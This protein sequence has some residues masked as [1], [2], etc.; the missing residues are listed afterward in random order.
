MSNNRLV[1]GNINA[2]LGY[3][4]TDY[5]VGPAVNMKLQTRS[6][7]LVEYLT[8]QNRSATERKSLGLLATSI[9]RRT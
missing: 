6:S 7:G 8:R 5:E 3:E 9:D 4:Y 1:G 2:S